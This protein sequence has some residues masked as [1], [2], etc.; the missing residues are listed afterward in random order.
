MLQPGETLL[1][2]TDGISEAR[3]TGGTL[4]GEERILEMMRE[5]NDLPVTEL[6]QRIM[7]A[8]CDFTGP[9]FPED[10]MTIVIV[11]RAEVK[12]TA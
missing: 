3:E 5:G 8:A 6:T 9:G 4:F 10:D 12:L 2:Y 11:K 7:R 1:L